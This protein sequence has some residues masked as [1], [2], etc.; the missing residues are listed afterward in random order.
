MRDDLGRIAAGKKAGRFGARRLGPP[1]DEA[2]ARPIARS[3]VYHAAHRAV[4]EVFVDGRQ[5]VGEVKVLTLDPA[6][7][8]CRLDLAH[9]RMPDEAPRRD[10]RGRSALEI[11]PLSLTLAD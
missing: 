3:F 9:H 5:V 8:A 2:G 10:C 6:E 11:T 7:A 1:A 4:R